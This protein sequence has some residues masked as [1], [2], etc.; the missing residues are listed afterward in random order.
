[1]LLE[2]IHGIADPTYQP[3]EKR[4][5]IFRYNF[6]VDIFHSGYALEVHNVSF[7]VFFQK[8]S[9]FRRAGDIWWTAEMLCE[10]LATNLQR[11]RTHSLT[12][13]SRGLIS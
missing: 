3:L 7:G 5:P 12:I 11:H 9:R 4:M 2:F 6:G 13:I 8:V 1:V 10:A